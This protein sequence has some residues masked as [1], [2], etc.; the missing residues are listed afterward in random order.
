[1]YVLPPEASEAEFRELLAYWQSKLLAGRLPGRQHIDPTDLQPRHLSQLLLLD[2]VEGAPPKLRRRYR[3][4]VAGTGFSAIAGHDVTGLHYD[5]IGAPER[6]LPVIRALDLVVER[7]APVFLS[8]R[9]SVPS[10]DYVWVK[11]LGLPLA[12]DGDK[13]DMVLAIWLAEGRSIADLARSDKERE[14]GVPQVLEQ[15]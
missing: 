9:L 6:A 13:V 15:R 3:F 11:R 4:R 14:A 7:K 2:V 10:Q 8:G 1:M 5:E 12:H